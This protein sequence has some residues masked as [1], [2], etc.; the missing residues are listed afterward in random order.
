[1]LQDFY[2]KFRGSHQ[3]VR[4]RYRAENELVGRF[5]AACDAAGIPREGDLGRELDELAAH[6][7]QREEALR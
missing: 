2:E 1:M 3:T 7:Q 5:L 6:H 4:A